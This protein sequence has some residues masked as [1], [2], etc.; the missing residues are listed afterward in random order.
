MDK[1]TTARQALF[2]ALASVLEDGRVSLYPPAQV[3]SPCVWIET[4]RGGLTQSGNSTLLL[5]SFPVVMVVDGDVKPQSLNLDALIARVHDRARTV[6]NV[7]GWSA[8]PIDVG[9]P[10]LRAAE[11]TVDIII[12]A[13]TLCD[14][15]IEM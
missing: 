10:T 12:T 1:L 13:R 15:P 5:A 14:P 3:V 7:N 2:D 9:G 6:G 11:M 4:S 8:R